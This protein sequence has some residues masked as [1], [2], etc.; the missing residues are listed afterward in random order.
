MHNTVYL[1][2]SEEVR[3]F[4]LSEI[5]MLC[6]HTWQTKYQINKKSIFVHTLLL[7]KNVAMKVI[8]AKSDIG[9]IIYNCKHEWYEIKY[10][11]SYLAYSYIFIGHWKQHCLLSKNAMCLYTIATKTFRTYF[12]SLLRLIVSFTK[13]TFV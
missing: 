7:I 13:S 2:H 10:N 9:Y 1:T 6:H 5:T 3:Q 11:V 12:W 8:L 4:L